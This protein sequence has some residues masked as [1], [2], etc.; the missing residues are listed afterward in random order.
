MKLPDQLRIIVPALVA[1][2]LVCLPGPTTAENFLK[3]GTPEGIEAIAGTEQCP[4]FPDLVKR[5]S[6]SVVNISV[7]ATAE[8]DT[9]ASPQLPFL[10]KDPEMPFRSVGSGFIVQED[11]YIVT[12]NHVIDKSERIIVRLL[13]DKTEYDATVM[14]RDTKTDLAL[15]KISAPH[16]LHTVHIG[17]SDDLQ[18]GEWVMAIGNQ[19]QLGHTVSAGIV[20]ALAR[21][22]RS[23]AGSPYDSYIQTDASINPGSSGGPLFNTRGQVVGVNTAIFTPGRSQI[24]GSGFNIGIGFAIPINL[25]QGVVT[26]IKERGKVTRGLLG[27]I[28]QPLDKD[29]AEALGL[30]SSDGALVADVNENTPASV[31]GFQR[32]D[33][34]L[35]FDGKKIADYDDL[36]V[37]VGDTPVGKSVKIELLRNGELRT[38]TTTIAEMKDAAARA[39]EP[40]AK[41]DELGL[42][43]G[44]IKPEVAQAFGKRVLSGVLVTGIETIS[45]AGRAGIDV[46]DIIEELGGRP[47]VDVAGYEKVKSSLDLKKPVLVLVRRKEGTRFSILRPSRNGKEA[48]QP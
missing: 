10:K 44:E 31:A 26:Q 20:S 42:V 11:G 12:N 39:E 41:P 18:V 38:L 32:K 33:V 6:S 14:G 24:G 34:I 48:R 21:K 4:R 40:A 46:G 3:Y 36:P 9:A 37:L 2:V 23:P 19:F 35:S 17:N 13:D 30:K 5:L 47:L 43:V 25:V 8:E 28:I 15:L 1:A 27:V 16:K 29:V 45:P 22:V 7:E